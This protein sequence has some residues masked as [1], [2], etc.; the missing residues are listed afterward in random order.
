[1]QYNFTAIK[2][3]EIVQ[4]SY[5]HLV[6]ISH[7]LC[8]LVLLMNENKFDISLTS[9]TFTLFASQYFD[10][11][12]Y[13][14]YLQFLFLYSGFH[15]TYA[16]PLAAIGYFGFETSLEI[17]WHRTKPN[18]GHASLE[19]YVTTNEILPIF[20]LNNVASTYKLQIKQNILT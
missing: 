4:C 20:I 10:V 16:P 8:I 17:M 11:R 9:C 14:S 5:T 13:I 18:I 3:F 15:P 6:D 1:M 19:R 2:C 12:V 7:V